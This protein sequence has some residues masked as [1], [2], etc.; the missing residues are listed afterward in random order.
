MADSCV[1]KFERTTTLITNICLVV[2]LLMLIALQI[3][4]TDAEQK[5]Y[6]RSGDGR[7]KI[8]ACFTVYFFFYLT[9]SVLFIVLATT[10]K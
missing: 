1:K 4:K 7:F 2:C 9:A 3:G 10:K 5:H 8:E 6:F